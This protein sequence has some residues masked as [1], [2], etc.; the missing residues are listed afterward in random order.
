MSD[1]IIKINNYNIITSWSYIMNTNT[2]CTICRQSLNSDSIYAI[3]KNIQSVLDT[4]KCGHMFH[5][6][7]I[8]PW[9]IANTKCPICSLSYRTDS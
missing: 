5:K 4:G 1:S 3:E 7:C 6:E 8:M 2:D 9:L